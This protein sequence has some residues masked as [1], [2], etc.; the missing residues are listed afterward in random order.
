MSPAEWIETADS[1]EHA[2]RVAW[3]WLKTDGSPFDRDMTLRIVARF[4]EAA[5]QIRDEH[6]SISTT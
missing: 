1:F 6:D 2:A 4:S 5:K 3:R